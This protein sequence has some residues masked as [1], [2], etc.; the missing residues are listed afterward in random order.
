MILDLMLPKKSGFD[1]LVELT[2][3]GID[4]PV[5]ILS[6]RD[7]EVDKVRGFDLGAA[8]YVTKPFSL[9]ELLA[10]VKARLRE[11]GADEVLRLG[12]RELDLARYRVLSKEGEVALT[13]T[14]VA[15]VKQLIARR[16]DLV[17]REE[18]LRGIWNLGPR[19]TRSLDTHVA[20]L[21]KKIEE[22]AS[23]PRHLLTVFGIGYRL[24]VGPKGSE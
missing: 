24:V 8:D 20:R 2:T 6:A 7:D 3:E 12:D 23:T 22:D 5:L 21:R 10:R 4:V 1:V 15:L 16:G 17:P 9:A 13:R 14:E 11:R 18:L 19:S